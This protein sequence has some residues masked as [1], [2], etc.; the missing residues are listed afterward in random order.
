MVIKLTWLSILAT[1]VLWLGA[2]VM[3]TSTPEETV[4]PAA[5][6]LEFGELVSG[7]ETARWENELG[8]WKPAVAVIDGV[9]KA[10]TSRYFK[11]N[12]YVTR[13]NLGE[14]LLIF[15]WDKEGSQ[16]SQQI[17]SRLI[18][19]PLGIFEGDQPLR[20]EDGRSIAPTVR[21]VITDRGQ[22]EGLSLADATRLSKQLN[23]GR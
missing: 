10:L 4:T 19:K 21:A 9:E 8:R 6:L 7:N 11:N 20:G 12:T 5:T 16:L 17:T 3:P 1:G 23:A 22:I 18:D 15:E 2:C 14:I 13:G